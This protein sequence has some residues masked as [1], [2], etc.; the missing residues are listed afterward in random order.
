MATPRFFCLD[1]DPGIVALDESESKHALGSLRLHA[2]DTAILFDGQ[3]RVA[4]GVLLPAENGGK[5]PH[6]EKRRRA[7]F[8]VGQVLCELPPR[9]RLTLIVAGCKGPRLT[10]MVEKLT[11]LGTSTIAITNFDRSVVRVGGAHEQR[12]RRTALQAAKQSQRA[13]LPRIV[14]GGTPADVVDKHA[15]DV[16][17]VA[18]PGE[19]S[20][21][22]GAA[23]HRSVT[24]PTLTVV[25]GPE[26][27]LT[28]AELAYLRDRSGIPVRLARTILRVE[29][30]AIS[31]AAHW[32]AQ[33][34]RV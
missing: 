24:S 15:E 6:R 33:H 17:L 8:E 14:C 20:V 2:G 21:A 5:R 18:H 22:L 4:R 1:L 25:V 28:D 13:W 23:L 19:G 9:C 10:W 16:L 11:E 31:L 7:R 34:L 26:G 12:L 3:G 27:G 30:A 29:T 32:A